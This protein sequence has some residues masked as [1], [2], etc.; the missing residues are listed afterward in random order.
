MSRRNFESKQYK[1]TDLEEIR[2]IASQL[3]Q[4]SEDMSR[5]A[6]EAESLDIS[7]FKVRGT[8]T[9]HETHL[10]EVSGTVA[11]FREMFDVAKRR[12]ALQKYGLGVVAEEPEQ[13]SVVAEAA[14]QAVRKHR[15]SRKD[16]K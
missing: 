5:V 8:K 14:A 12:F 6:E 13:L 3:K 1:D 10:P 11:H 9:F 7:V 4:L 2:Y 15:S 16:N